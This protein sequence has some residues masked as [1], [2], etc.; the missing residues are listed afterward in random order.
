MHRI[1]LNDGSFD[2]GNI[3]PGGVSQ[4]VRLAGVAGGQYHCT[5]HPTMM[6]G[7]VNTMS[8]TTPDSTGVL[9]YTR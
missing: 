8:A 3:P 4:P 5:I 1:V 6:F 9:P 2:S 7:R